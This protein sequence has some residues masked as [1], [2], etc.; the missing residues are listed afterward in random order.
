MS[1]FPEQVHRA[2]QE[3]EHYFKLERYEQAKEKFLQVLEGSPEDG[4]TLYRIAFCCF[5]LHQF[6]EAHDFC[7]QAL[8]GGYVQEFTYA[9]LGAI[10]VSQQE[11][12]EAE[13]SLLKALSLNPQSA[14]VIAQYAY[15]MLRT[16]H[17][18]KAN[19]L[20]QEA[21]RIDPQNEVVLHY[22]FYFQLASGEKEEQ[23]HT[24][25]NYMDSSANEIDKLVKIGISAIHRKNYKEARE[26][27]R[28]AYLLDPT[29]TSILQQLQTLDR[30]THPIFMPNRMIQK[31]GGPLVV[32]IAFIVIMFVLSS[33]HLDVVQTVVGGLYLLFCIYS[34]CA[35]SIYK[36][37]RKIGK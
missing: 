30:V 4:R 36:V 25:Q 31:I 33:L 3:A 1:D 10:Q 2:L 9:L 13:D 20:I 34:W 11:Y 17:E 22:S 8:M 32:W 29:N 35:S 24:I 18:E 27:F 28:Q 21:L 5:H 12:V 15:L 14:A 16:G 26:C 7:T 19:R 37:V 23:Q 6:E